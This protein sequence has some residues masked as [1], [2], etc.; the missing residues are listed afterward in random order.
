MT[1][2]EIMGLKKI[3]KNLQELLD[4]DKGREARRLTAVREL[5][6]KLEKKQAKFNARL[7]QPQSEKELKKLKRHIKVCSAQLEKG[8]AALNV[9]QEEPKD[10]S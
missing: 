8:R 10:E 5:V 1:G 2:S 7:S 4:V 3:V 6:E 9:L